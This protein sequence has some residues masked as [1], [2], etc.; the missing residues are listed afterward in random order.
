MIFTIPFLIFAWAMWRLYAKYAYTPRSVRGNTV[1]ITG[2]AGGIGRLMALRFA[3]QGANLVLWDMQEAL[4]AKTKAEIEAQG[5]KCGTAVI[6]ITDRAKVYEAAQTVGAVDILVLNAGV[7]SGKKFLEIPDDKIQRTF[8]VNTMSHFWAL[9][10][11]LP[12]M[13]ERN[14]GHVVSIASV[15]GLFGN[16]GQVDYSASKFAAV[17]IADSLYTELRH[18]K[19]KVKVT[20]VCPYYINTGMFDGVKSNSLL[21]ILEQGA[22]AS[23]I[24]SGVLKGEER[25]ILP[26][27]LVG[28]YLLKVLPWPIL[29]NL[30]NV[31]GLMDTMDDFKGRA[32]VKA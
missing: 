27:R 23:R 1:L 31:L 22:V 5:V 2:G 9:K 25:I 14:S 29:Y 15:A 30:A 7:V 12:G 6:D 17:G 21:P 4:L 13:I 8:E 11:F 24:V 18:I 20:C 10:A 3:A 28:I 19:S 32:A 26:G 16:P